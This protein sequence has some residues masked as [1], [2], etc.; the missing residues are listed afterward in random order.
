MNKKSK[1]IVLAIGI[2]AC[3]VVGGGTFFYLKDNNKEEMTVVESNPDKIA[4]G[5]VSFTYTTKK[6]KLK[7]VRATQEELESNKEL[8]EKW[9]EYKQNVAVPS[10]DEEINNGSADAE[11]TVNTELKYGPSADEE[12]VKEVQKKIDSYNTEKGTA[13]ST[14]CNKI[15]EYA[16]KY[17][18]EMNNGKRDKDDD[19]IKAY[20]ALK[21][22][23][24][25]KNYELLKMS[26]VAV[27]GNDYNG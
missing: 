24:S 4:D 11:G 19:F 25:E 5:T 14:K 7:Q 17:Y 21:E 26:I 20:N 22:K 18:D 2:T 16:K 9:E 23:E 8:K 1:K 10:T 6:G 13:N 12:K 3:V 15:L 27:T